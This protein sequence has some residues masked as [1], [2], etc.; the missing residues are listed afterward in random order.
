MPGLPLSVTPYHFAHA[1]VMAIHPNGRIARLSAYRIV[2]RKS[3]LPG[4]S[5]TEVRFKPERA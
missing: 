2:T 3:R 5:R 1:Q 4:F